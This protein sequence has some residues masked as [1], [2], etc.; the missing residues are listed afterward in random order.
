MIHGGP[1]SL[2]EEGWTTVTHPGMGWKLTPS[3]PQRPWILAS[4]GQSALP[5]PR[6]RLQA[7]LLAHMHRALWGLGC[8]DW[9]QSASLIHLHRV[10][11][12]GQDRPSRVSLRG[13]KSCN[14]SLAYQRKW[15]GNV[16]IL[17]SFSCPC[18]G[19]I[20]FIVAYSQCINVFLFS[21]V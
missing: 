17:L 21:G 13:G 12:G 10:R 15:S 6:S 19:S 14:N 3:T 8:T 2:G 1:I 4:G 16:N 7:C 11:V 20:G 18:T 5:W 9:L